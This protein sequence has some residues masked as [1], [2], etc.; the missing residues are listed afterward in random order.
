MFFPL[1]AI[2]PGAFWMGLIAGAEEFFSPIYNVELA[3]YR[4]RATPDPLRGR[5]SST[6]LWVMQGSNALGALLSG[7]LI[8]AFSARL[9]AVI[10]GGWL[11]LLAVIATLSRQVRTARVDSTNTLATGTA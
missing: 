11:I 7:I 1:Y 9:S 10:L 8:Q 3:S 6:V 4:L 5:V 2:A